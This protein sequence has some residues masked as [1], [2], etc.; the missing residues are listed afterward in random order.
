MLRSNTSLAGLITKRITLLS[1]QHHFHSSRSYHI[2]LRKLPIALSSRKMASQKP[3][4]RN[5]EPLPPAEA[6][7]ISFERIHWTDAHGKNRTWEAANRTTR[8]GAGVDA[9]AIAPIILQDGQP[10]STLIILQYRPPVDTICVEFP[11]GLIDGDETAEQAAIREMA[12]ET[13]F[14]NIKIVDVSRSIANDPGMSMTNMILAVAEI[15]MEKDE[16]LPEQHLEEGED[17]ERVIVPLKELYQT[18][19]DL[20]KEGKMVDARLWHWAAGIKF[21]LDYRTRFALE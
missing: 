8:G 1:N 20:Q 21:A 2:P 6:K 4:I 12:E 18:L 11:A 7:W 14:D 3:V 9:V 17:I 13:G 16:P 5:I 15:H 10:A 19:V